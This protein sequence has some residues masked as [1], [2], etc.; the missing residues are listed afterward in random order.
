MKN[1]HLQK[2]QKIFHLTKQM[3]SFQLRLTGGNLM[4]VTGV[5]RNF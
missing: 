5:K 2:Q 3:N 4:E 1:S